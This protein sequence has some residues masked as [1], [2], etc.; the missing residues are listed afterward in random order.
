M[1]AVECMVEVMGLLI[2]PESVTSVQF[3]SRSSDR[4]EDM[5]Y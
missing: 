4:N 1:A 5:V 2:K 3:W